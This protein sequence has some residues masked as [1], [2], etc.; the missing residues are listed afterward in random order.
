MAFRDAIQS[1]D[2]PALERQALPRDG[3]LV[4]SGALVEPGGG[5]SVGARRV[6]VRESELRGVTLDADNSPGLELTDAV[7]RDCGLSN[8]DARE[9]QIRRAELRHCQ[10]VGFSFALGE[11]EN[12]RLIDCSLELASL[13]SAR[14]RN[15]SFERVNLAEASFMEA[16]LEAVEF[17]DCRLAGA[18][19]RGAR[20]RAS[21]VR[22]ASLDGV[23]GVESLRGLRMP[24]SDAIASAG[25]M[26]VALGIVIDD[27]L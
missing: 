11:L 15:V 24:W 10:M 3:E 23:L 21:A 7:L 6:R 1:P 25:A 20:V 16:R 8:V 12:V 27:Q 18:D 5:G 9:G 2:L 19:F 13:A 17:V 26:A 14:L 22:G 4:L